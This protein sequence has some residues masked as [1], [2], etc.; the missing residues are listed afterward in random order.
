MKTV[1]DSF[2]YSFKKLFMKPLWELCETPGILWRAKA[3]RFLPYMELTFQHVESD[4]KHSKRQ[5]SLQIVIGAMEEGEQFN[6]MK[7][8]L[9][10]G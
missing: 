7:S 8:D 5:R 9:G 4:D 1:I 3:T 6:G 2:I 10:G